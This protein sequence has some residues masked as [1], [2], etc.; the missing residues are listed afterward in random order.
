VLINKEYDQIIIGAGIVGISLGLAIL[1]RNPNRKVLI[2]EKEERAGV[3][4][5]GR[6]SGVLHAGF[7]Y[8]PDSLKAKFCRLGNLELRKFCKENN[9]QILETG[10]VVVCQDGQDVQ[11]LEELYRRGVANGVNIEMLDSRDLEK[12]EPAAQTFNKFIWSPTSAVGSPKDVINKLADKFTQSG[13]RFSFNTQVKL[14]EKGN[15]VLVLTKYETYSA[16]SIIN[17]AGAYAA[18]LAKQ[19]NVGTEYVCLPFLGA[20]KRSKL[21]SVNPK[22][23]VYPVPNPINPFLGV[24][25]TLTLN[26]E[27]KIGPTAFPVIGKEQYKLTDGFNLKEFVEFFNASSALFK[28]ESVDLLGLAKEEALK[29]FEKPLLRRTRKLSNSIDSNNS[30]VKYPSGIRAQIINTKTKTI[31][32]DYIVKADKNVVHVLNAVSPGWTSS[33]P[34]AHWVVENQP[35]LA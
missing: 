31:E 6:N 5:S 8:S 11:R 24:H 29:F 19:V 22:R 16:K 18:E 12:I 10:K 7:Y 25:T 2:V 21:L 28:S 27:I 14:A 35:L 34:F 17:S 32:M 30:W 13:G 4:A 1:E 23:L 3:H 26:N 9:L 20:Y 15:E 33:I